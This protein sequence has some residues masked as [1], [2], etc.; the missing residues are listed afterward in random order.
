MSTD[1]FPE[2]LVER[3]A[4]CGNVAVA[5]VEDPESAVPLARAL[6]AGGV[7]TIELTFRT[8]KALEALSRITSEVPEMLVGAG[9]V[10]TTE[11]L[12]DALDAGAAFAVAPGFNPDIVRAAADIGIPFAPGVMTPSEIEG[13]YAL[14]CT[15]LLKFFPAS[16]AGGLAGLRTLAAPYRHLGLR[17]L[18]LGGLKRENTA[19]WL[20]EPL[21]AACGG[22]WIAPAALIAANDWEAIA[23]NAAAA[24]AAA[25]SRQI[26]DSR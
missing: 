17:F 24:A 4:R 3:I 23:A 1:M 5:V 22:S 15:R 25:A 18:P 20:S 10:L 6:L 19:E 16:V 13:A 12:R 7:E 11:Q 14:G 26:I 8:P 9:T 21:V 2:A